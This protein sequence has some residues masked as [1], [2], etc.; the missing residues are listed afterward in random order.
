MTLLAAFWILLCVYLLKIIFFRVGMSRARRGGASEDLPPVSVIIAARNE[1]RNIDS[2]L[3]S[4]A[5]LEYPG[6]KLEIIAIDDNSTDDTWQRMQTWRDRM[7][8]LCTLR[9]EGVVHGMKG[10][11]NA[12]AQAIEQSRGEIIMTTDADCEAPPGWVA[13][14]VRQ[15]A[16]DTGCVCGFTLLK[17]DGQFAGM[18]SVDWAYMLSIASAGVGWSL[19]LSA[20]GNN[21]SF[22]RQAYDDVGGYAG[23]GFSVTEDFALFKAIGYR[24]RW[25]IR[26][27]LRKETLVWSAPCADLRELYLQ[28]KRWGKG[29]LKIHP[30][31]FAIMSV[32]FLMSVAVLALPWTGFPLGAYL[33][34]IAGK[35]AG[36]AFLLYGTLKV[37]RQ[38]RLFRYFPLFELYYVLYVSL[39][40]FVVL[41][42][43]RVNWKGR[44]L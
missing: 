13:E 8:A 11:A 38:R 1:S 14:T 30:L 44:K 40:P 29:G 35:C 24:T 2:C 7:P 10:K 12:V 25:K 26:Y 32:G 15:Y 31:G 37:L 27:P 5:R 41:L 17:T 9:T 19:P 28:K 39:L 20:V 23:V 18:Q 4:L 16:A 22:R 43:G 36:D 33:A 21:M 42:T 3:A 6:E 34:G